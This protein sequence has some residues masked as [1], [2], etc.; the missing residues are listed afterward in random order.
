MGAWNAARSSAAIAVAPHFM[1]RGCSG[2]GVTSSTGAVEFTSDPLEPHESGKANKRAV[3]LI[4][5]A[6]LPQIG[7][8][9]AAAP[10]IAEAAGLAFGAAGLG[11]I[12]V[13][14]MTVAMVALM[15]NRSMF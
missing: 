4:A 14:L 2:R 13:I 10:L 1:L 15:T 9:I 11:V 12:A 7:I 6:A 8:V 3:H 5:A